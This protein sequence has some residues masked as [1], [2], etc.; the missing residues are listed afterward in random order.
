[1]GKLDVIHSQIMK[2]KF[3][4][5]QKFNKLGGQLFSY[6]IFLPKT[7]GCL[8]IIL[9]ANSE[10]NLEL[11]GEIFRVCEGDCPRGPVIPL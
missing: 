7:M 10:L 6:F 4:F 11:S 5:N 2:A 3:F 9:L 8:N 1:M